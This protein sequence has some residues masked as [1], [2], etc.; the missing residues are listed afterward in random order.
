MPTLSK[1]GAMSKW[2]TAVL[3]FGFAWSGANV[4]ARAVENL[5]EPEIVKI[6]VYEAFFPSQITPSEGAELIL[7]WEFPSTCF[8]APVVTTRINDTDQTIWVQI[9]AKYFDTH[10]CAISV[11]PQVE[12]VDLGRLVAADY[13]VLDSVPQ[14]SGKKLGTLKVKKGMGLASSWVKVDSI[15]FVAAG[16]ARIHGRLPSSCGGP[17]EFRTQE[18]SSRFVEVFPYA[19]SAGCTGELKEWSRDFDIPVDEQQSTVVYSRSLGGNRV[20]LYSPFVN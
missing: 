19:P 5:T 11:I 14:K 7:V 20:G 1:S 2:M 9:T 17:R 12:R 4:F 18:T 6:P 8:Y 10:F 16:R 13:T 15:E 3:A